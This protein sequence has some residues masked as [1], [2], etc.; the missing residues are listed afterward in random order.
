MD[1]YKTG[2]ACTADAAERSGQ[3]HAFPKSVALL[4]P[5][6]GF[7]YLRKREYLFRFHI[8]MICF[9]LR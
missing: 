6:V 8:N 1:L 7:R 2:P 4:Q 9:N 5:P 3:Y